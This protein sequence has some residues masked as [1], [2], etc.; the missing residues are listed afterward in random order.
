M[1]TGDSSFDEMLNGKP[2]LAELCEH[3]PIST[4]WYITGILLELNVRKLN[5]IEDLPK[6]VPYK[7]SKMYE[8][9]LD[10]KPQATRRQIVDKLK[11]ETVGQM[12]LA[13]QYETKLKDHIPVISKI[14]NECI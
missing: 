4:N 14:L 12:S 5:E 8:L 9:W 7:V 6:P 2:T 11:M 1:A 10:T 3:V 13:H